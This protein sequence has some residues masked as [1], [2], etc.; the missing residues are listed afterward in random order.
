MD[1]LKF[2]LILSG[3]LIL[4]TGLFM[5]F[6]ILVYSLKEKDNNGFAG[7]MI[8]STYLSAGVYCLIKGIKRKPQNDNC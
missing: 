7:L 2:L 1:G 8:T 4:L 6:G 5:S 3:I